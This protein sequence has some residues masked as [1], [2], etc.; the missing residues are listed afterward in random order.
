MEFLGS[1]K[2]ENLQTG[3]IQHFPFLF[4][5]PLFPSLAKIS[6]IILKSGGEN[7]HA[8]LVPDFMFLAFKGFV[9]YWSYA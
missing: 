9:V 4:V 6:S 7:R 2:Y 5:S 8:C 3:I 1:S